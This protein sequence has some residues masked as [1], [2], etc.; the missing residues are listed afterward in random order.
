MTWKIA[1]R[2]AVVPCLVA[3]L[4]G[5]GIREAGFV[6]RARPRKKILKKKPNQ[7][8]T[9]AFFFIFVVLLRQTFPILCHGHKK[10]RQEKGEEEEQKV[11]FALLSLFVITNTGP[12]GRCFFVG[13]FHR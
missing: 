1:A 4:L 10:T 11:T 5:G 12:Q 8:L 13:N 3:G 7:I 9:N 2:P 6:D